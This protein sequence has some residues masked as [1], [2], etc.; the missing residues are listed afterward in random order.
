MRRLLEAIDR[1]D[2]EATRV[3]RAHLEGVWRGLNALVGASPQRAKNQIGRGPRGEQT[4]ELAVINPRARN[5]SR[6]RR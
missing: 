4:G 6:N 5:Q 1:D 3:E 2:L